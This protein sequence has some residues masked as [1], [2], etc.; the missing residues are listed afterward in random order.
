MALSELADGASSDD[1]DD[2]QSECTYN[3][4]AFHAM[5]ALASMYVAMMINNWNTI[6]V[7][8][9]MAAIGQSWQSVWV[10][11]ISS[12]L[13]CLLYVWTLVAPIILPDRAW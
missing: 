6:Q 9:G 11:M 12:W 3:Y 4:S 1:F 2:E 13:V 8:D 5:Y 7:T 10:K